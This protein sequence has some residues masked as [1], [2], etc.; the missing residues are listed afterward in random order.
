MVAALIAATASTLIAVL[1]YFLNSSGEIARASHRAEL[2]WINSQ[3]R[4]LYGPLFVLSAANE[5]TWNEFRDRHLPEDPALRR[6]QALSGDQEKLWQ[7]WLVAVFVPTARTMRDLIVSHGDLIIENQVPPV[8]LDFC[9]HVA[10]YEALLVDE[11][12]ANGVGAVLVRH[13]GDDFATYVRESY[14]QLKGNQAALRAGARQLRLRPRS[15]HARRPA[16]LGGG[17]PQTGGDKGT[18]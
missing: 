13:P 6:R 9:A 7:R 17:R 16:E 14:R 2:E 1:A 3:L 12:T 4:D 5:R 15:P 18:A 10:S 11:A 8:V